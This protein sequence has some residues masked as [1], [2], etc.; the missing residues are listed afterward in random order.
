MLSHAPGRGRG[1]GKKMKKGEEKEGKRIGSET[2]L[3][4]KISKKPKNI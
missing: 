1:R 4:D 3:C 2:S